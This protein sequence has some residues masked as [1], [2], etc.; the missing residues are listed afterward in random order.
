MLIFVLK[1]EKEGSVLQWEFIKDD[2]NNERGQKGQHKSKCLSLYTHLEVLVC[3]ERRAVA[4]QD[5]QGSTHASS[6]ASDVDCTYVV[7]D[8][9]LVWMK[10]VWCVV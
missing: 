1:Q 4:T 10:V 9:D 7:V 5:D 6:V 8:V 2:D 3:D